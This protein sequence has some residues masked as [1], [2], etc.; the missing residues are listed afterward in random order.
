MDDQTVDAIAFMQRLWAR[1]MLPDIKTFEPVARSP[2]Q[3]SVLDVIEATINETGRP[4]KQ[5][6]IAAAIGISTNS[7][8]Q[9]VNKLR[10]R[11]G[12]KYNSDYMELLVDCT[13]MGP[14]AWEA[15]QL[16]SEK[17]QAEHKKKL[18]K[19]GLSASI[20]TR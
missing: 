6:E 13:P 12:L 11:R 16:F 9:I 17:K 10:Q 2:L 8:H 1:D 18:L 4:P 19:R 7:A 14:C 15:R 20:F 3:Q 5:T